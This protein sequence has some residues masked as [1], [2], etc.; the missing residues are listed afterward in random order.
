MIGWLGPLLLL[1]LSAVAFA[2]EAS[3]TGGRALPG[4]PERPDPAARYLVYLHGAIVEELG[5]EAVSEEHGRYEYAAIVERFAGAGF[6][7]IGE[8]RP[9]GTD[10]AGFA[11][12]V[13]GQVRALLAAGVAPE[14]ITV[15]GASKGAVIAMLVSSRVEAGVR[16]VLLAGC[17]ERIFAAYPAS[18]H[19]DVLSIQEASDPIGGS[20]RPLFDRSPALGARDEILLETGLRHGFLYRPLD[21]W[22]LP[23][24]AWAKGEAVPTR[25]KGAA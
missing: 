24:L 19:G 17:N 5:A 15:L 11:D 18:L 23:A 12:R 3:A 1:A 21:A 6:V 20:C 14:R 25:S 9:S 8:L 16:Y 4:P 22:L 2:G 13:A 10:P 7:V